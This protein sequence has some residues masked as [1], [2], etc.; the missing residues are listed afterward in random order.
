MA[1][2]YKEGKGVPQDYEFA[3]VWYSIGAAHQHQLS[4]NALDSA[5]EK[6]SPDEMKEAN[7]LIA[8]YVEKYGPKEDE[9]K[10]QTN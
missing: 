5:E 9:N 4:I 6:L 2:L 1:N 10:Q 7:K 8:D 3:Y